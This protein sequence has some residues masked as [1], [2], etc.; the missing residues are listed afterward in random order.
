[1]KGTNG[2][3]AVTLLF[4]YVNSGFEF[5]VVFNACIKRSLSMAFN[6]SSPLPFGQFH[7]SMLYNSYIKTGVAVFYQAHFLNS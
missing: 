5:A 7:W 6:C 1:M 4:S 2:V 3:D